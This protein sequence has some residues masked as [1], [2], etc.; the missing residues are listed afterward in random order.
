MTR[1]PPG[2]GKH[3]PLAP[4]GPRTFLQTLP[5]PGLIPILPLLFLEQEAPPVQAWFLVGYSL[6]SGVTNAGKF[7]DYT[8][9]RYTVPK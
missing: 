2:L 6:A 7:L 3:F 1:G 5:I 9:N 4:F 8:T